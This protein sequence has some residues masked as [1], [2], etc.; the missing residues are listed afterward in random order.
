MRSVIIPWGTPFLIGY[1]FEFEPLTTTP[2]A[3]QFS[4][5]PTH[6]S[7]ICPDLASLFV[8][9]LSRKTVSQALLKSRKV[10]IC[11][12][13]NNFFIDSNQTGQ[14]PLALDKSMSAFSTDFLVLHTLPQVPVLVLC[15]I[16]Q[17]VNCFPRC[18]A[19]RALSYYGIFLGI[20]K[21]I[22]EFANIITKSIYS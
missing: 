2:W 10:T 9:R 20:N 17:G 8:R 22:A 3:R 5:I 16:V 15:F 1:Q 11:V 19:L 4:Q 14:M 12:L 13:E 6:L 7:S 21:T 18:W